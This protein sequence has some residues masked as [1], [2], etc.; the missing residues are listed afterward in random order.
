MKLHEMAV[1]LSKAKGAFV[2]NLPYLN[3]HIM[4]C[5]VYNY[6]E[7]TVVFWI[8]Q[9]LL[10]TL[11]YLAN[12]NVKTKSGKISKEDYV[13]MM[14]DEFGEDEFDAY[15]NL[16]GLHKDNMRSRKYPIAEPDE[17]MAEKL[18]DVYRKVILYISNKFST[19]NRIEKS[20]IR[21][22][23]FENIGPNKIK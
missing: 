6:M 18:F 8:N 16:L 13:S 20:E 14:V 1:P 10:P 19:E 3:E 21:D 11:H 7:T 22:W 17:E 4:K 12:M 2:D 5:V 15:T 9:E 23:L